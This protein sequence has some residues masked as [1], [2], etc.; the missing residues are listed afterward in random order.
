MIIVVSIL[1]EMSLPLTAVFK[2]KATISD[3]PEKL[4][5]TLKMSCSQDIFIFGQSKFL[6]P[7]LRVITAA[8]PEYTVSP[9]VC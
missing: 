6:Q 3:L 1:R 8:T 9:E 2:L 4:T 5:F 7:C